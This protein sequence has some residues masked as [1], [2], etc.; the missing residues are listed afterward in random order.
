MPGR[1]WSIATLSLQLTVSQQGCKLQTQ[2]PGFMMPGE[3]LFSC[4]TIERNLTRNQG[5][6]SIRECYVPKIRDTSLVE[7]RH[8][9]SLAREDFLHQHADVRGPRV[10]C[11]LQDQHSIIG[12][13][14]VLQNVDITQAG[15]T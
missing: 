5:V 6:W 9:W 7:V 14:G 4:N 13:N 3:E 1:Q 11:V 2:M 10:R 8:K 12:Y 15:R